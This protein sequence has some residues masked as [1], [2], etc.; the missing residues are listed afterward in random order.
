MNYNDVLDNIVDNIIEV[1]ASKKYW[2]IRTQSGSLYETFIENNFVGIDH[3]E[4]SLSTLTALKQNHAGNNS[5]F[6]DSIKNSV[7][8][9]YLSKED[10]EFEISTQRIGLISGQI[11]KFYELVK[12]GDVVIIPSTNSETVSFGLIT[13]SNIANFTEE[14][15]R[16]FDASTQ[17]LNKRVEWLTDFQ[18][19]SLDPNIF[20]MFTAHH[21][22]SDVSKYADII[23][24]SLHDF[25]VLDHKAHLIINVQQRYDIR[26]KDLFGVGYAFLHMVDSFATELNISGVD[27]EDLQVTVNL[28]SPGKID[29]KSTVKK[30]TV[31]AGMILAICGGG[32]VASD[33]S[34]LKTDGIRSL[35]EAISEYQ[36]EKQDR[37]LQ[38]EIFKTYKD[39]LNI[40]RPEDMIRLLKQVDKNQD[41]AK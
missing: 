40:K 30:T 27:S 16:K 36:N 26:A 13:E 41:L 1:P 32:Y 39:S 20:K 8:K 23:E 6:L 34:S 37:D 38:M 7:R 14:E 25:F 17:F 15:S 29:L 28:N 19:K 21:A 22:I 9:H 2:L 3:R 18:R 24:R 12:K 31:F 33:G 5:D 35:I 4:I 10:E 11:Y